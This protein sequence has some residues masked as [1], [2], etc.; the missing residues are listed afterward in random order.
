V[1]VGGRD[2][3]EDDNGN[4]N[5]QRRDTKRPT[6]GNR[7]R[8]PTSR[9]E[10][11]A[12]IGLLTGEFALSGAAE[13][14]KRAFGGSASDDNVFFNTQG[15]ER[16]AKR[17]ARMRGAAMKIGQMIS[18]FDEELL[19]KEFAEALAILRDSGDTMPESQVRKSLV[20]AYGSQWW[21]KFESFDFEPIA[22]ASIGQVHTGMTKDGK[23]L[24]IKIQYP[25]VAESIES[26]VR[27]LAT[28][29]KAARILPVGLDIDGIVDEAQRQLQQESDYLLE[30][31]YLR[32]YKELLGDD[33]RYCIPDLYDRLCTPRM[34]A[35]ERLFGV[36]LEDLAGAGHDQRARDEMGATL[37]ELLFRELFEFGLMQTDPN[38]SN[39]LLIQDGKLGLLDFGST[40]V[41]DNDLAGQYRTLFLALIDQDRDRIKAAIKDI[42]FL[43][44]EDSATVREALI[45]LFVLIFSPMGFEGAFDFAEA[46]IMSRTQERAMEL[47]FKHGYMRAPPAH[48]IFLQRKLDG[49][50]L[51]CTKIKARVNVKQILKKVLADTAPNAPAS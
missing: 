25:G 15:A 27:N 21:K 30:A 29:L 40:S 47:A 34:L 1:D 6:T 16:L 45:D 12:R 20:T 9:I 42:G 14:V 33:P 4:D 2:D 13:S 8:V 35:M 49:T 51:L 39:Y 31:D 22:A 43:M 44:A 19:P 37:F 11:F 23:E 32:R 5:R 38:F 18:L 48:T 7:T 17:L 46:N 50:V 28:A 24:A 10:R 3:D 26:D 41:I 36:P